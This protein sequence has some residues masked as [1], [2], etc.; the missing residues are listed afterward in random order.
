MNIGII[1]LVQVDLK[2]LQ[3]LGLKHLRSVREFHLSNS[4]WVINERTKFENFPRLFLLN[5]TKI[6]IKNFH[7]NL[8]KNLNKLEILILKKCRIEKIDKNGFKNLKNLKEL[9]LNSTNII[10]LLNIQNIKDLNKIQF[11][12]SKYFRSCCF[13]KKSNIKIRKCL[14]FILNEQIC[15]GIFPSTF[16]WK[17]F[18]LEFLK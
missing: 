7:K 2:S 4:K 14:P 6:R 13:V 3:F 18:V 11:L 1:Q 17:I 12:Y 5:I 15:F 10:E 9:H 16:A 8:M